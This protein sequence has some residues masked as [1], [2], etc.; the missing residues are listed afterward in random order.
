MPGLW[1]ISL[2]VL[3][4]MYSMYWGTSRKLRSAAREAMAPVSSSCSSWSCDTE[5]WDGSDSRFRGPADEDGEVM[6]RLRPRAADALVRLDFVMRDE[7]A[8]VA[9]N[10]ILNGL[11]AVT[12]C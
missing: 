3:L 7:R 2:K 12:V 8:G 11:G 5:R 10:D 9:W 1:G 6:A 4:R